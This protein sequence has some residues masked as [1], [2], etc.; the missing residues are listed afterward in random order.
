MH[1]SGIAL[2]ALTLAGMPS[3]AAAQHEFGVDIVGMYAKQAGAAGAL[4]IATP[5][6]LRVGFTAGNRLTIEPRIAVFYHSKGGLDSALNEVATYRFVPSVTF[7]WSFQSHRRGP[8][9]TA[10]VA[11]DIDHS[12]FGGAA[13]TATQFGINGGIGTRVPYESG[14]I[15]LEAFGRYWFKNTSTGL[16]NELDVGGKVGLSLWHGTRPVASAQHETG[17]A[18]Q[19]ELGADIVGVYAKQPGA[20]GAFVIATPVDLRA[21]FMVSDKLTI[22]PRIS[23]G[24]NSKGGS[25][26]L[27]QAVAAYLLVPDLNFLW[28]F[29]RNRR[30][31]YVT[32]G[33]GVVIAHVPVFGFRTGTT[34]QFGIN[35]GIGTRVPYESGA[36]RLEAFGRY[37]LRN[38]NNGLPKE[39]NVGVRIGI[40]LWH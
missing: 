31:P 23:F 22:E 17:H 25:D 28:A 39:L 27:F 37:F 30:G 3:V 36:I 19:H 2:L 38:T 4:V 40:S 15:R 13:V 35:G 33:A 7:L 18:A 11:A 32:G 26:S 6:D 34:T 12:A 9:I 10:G 20:A 8:F 29:Q 21:G 1:K 14:A 24:Y 5:V 16:P